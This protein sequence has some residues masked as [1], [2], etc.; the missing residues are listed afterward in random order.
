MSERLSKNE[1]DQKLKDLRE[2]DLAGDT[3][4]K[5]YS[6]ESFMPAIQF[7]S[8]VADLAEAADHHPDIKIN[9]RRVTMALSTHS[10]GGLTEKDFALAKKIDGAV[11]G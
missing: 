8:R 9:Y 3:I 4:K 10:A 7:V 1:I 5:Q 2:W 11:I 6:F